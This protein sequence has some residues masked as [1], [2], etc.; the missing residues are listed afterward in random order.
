MCSWPAFLSRRRFQVAP[1][2][3]G[4]SGVAAAFGGRVVALA[5]ALGTCVSG[6]DGQQ[7][8]TIDFAHGAN[9]VRA[10]AGPPLAART[11]R[12]TDLS[13]GLPGP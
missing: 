10:A 11:V 12:D 5:S 9:N 2:V 1:T 6:R 13:R 3:I 4:E 7:A 8:I